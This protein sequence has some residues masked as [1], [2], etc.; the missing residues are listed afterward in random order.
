MGCLAEAC[1]QLEGIAVVGSSCGNSGS[2]PDL[3]EVQSLTCLCTMPLYTDN[4]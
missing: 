2:N 3:M 4:G 1:D